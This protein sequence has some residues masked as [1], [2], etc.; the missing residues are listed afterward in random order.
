MYSKSEFRWGPYVVRFP[1]G[2]KVIDPGTVGAAKPHVLIRGKEYK[3]CTGCD[4]WIH[5]GA[6]GESSYRWDRKNNICS[7][8]T[9]LFSSNRNSHR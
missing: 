9:S 6:F 7:S 2:S 8:C 1:R 4:S 3:H 5:V